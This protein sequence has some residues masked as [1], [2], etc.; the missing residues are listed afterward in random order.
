[1]AQ[2]KIRALKQKAAASTSKAAE[3]D[4]TPQSNSVK[5]DSVS[6][7]IPA[8]ACVRP[9]G[10]FEIQIGEK[11]MQLKSSKAGDC[12]HLIEFANVSNVIS[13]KMPTTKEQIVVLPL[14][15]PLLVGKTQHS[16]LVFKF[17]EQEDANAKCVKTNL[18]GVSADELRKL[19]KQKA[20]L[21]IAE[22]LAIAAERKVEKTD[23]GVFRAASG[24]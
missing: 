3:K 20:Y 9:W 4:S 12:P 23:F 21:C 17:K 19:A 2:A 13:V 7:T 18:R 10:K 22:W 14:E 5:M 15:K 11:C 6:I 8:I 16:V 24:K 1:M